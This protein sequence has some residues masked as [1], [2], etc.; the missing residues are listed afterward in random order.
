MADIAISITSAQLAV[1]R[2][3]DPAVSAKAVLQAHVDTWLAPL[4][5]EMTEFDKREITRAYDRASVDVQ[6]R[7]K[8]ELGLG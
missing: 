2:K 5:V 7:I 3:L 8:T 1:L 4:V 6:Q